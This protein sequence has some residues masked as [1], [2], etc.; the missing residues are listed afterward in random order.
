MK[1]SEDTC[2]R[3]APCANSQGLALRFFLLP[4]DHTNPSE[5]LLHKF[6]ERHALGVTHYLHFRVNW[7]V[8]TRDSRQVME[9][10]W[11]SLYMEVTR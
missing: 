3:C 9:P 6:W 7:E 11:H 1:R 8:K 2:C 10:V 5:L 4:G